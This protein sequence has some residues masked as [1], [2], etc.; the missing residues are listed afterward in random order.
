MI[1]SQQNIKSYINVT[2]GIIKPSVAKQF[3]LLFID[4]YS[5][6]WLQNAQQVHGRQNR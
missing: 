2:K 1:T 3:M 4:I 6:Q 5:I